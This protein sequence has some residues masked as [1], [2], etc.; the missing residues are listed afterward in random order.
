VAGEGRGS[1]FNLKSDLLQKG[2]EFSFFQVMR[3]LRLLGGEREMVRGEEPW[4][5]P[6]VRVHPDLSMA[7]PASDVVKVEEG[8]GESAAFSV[9]TSFLGL[10]GTSSPLPTFYTEDLVNEAVEDVS[11]TRGFIDIVNHR[12]YLLLFRSWAKYRPFLQVVEE[13]NSREAERLFCLTGLGEEELRKDVL[14]AYGLLRYLGLFTQ[15]P[16]SALGLVTLLQ[17]ALEVRPI[18]VIPCVERRVK[19]PPDQQ[20]SLGVSGRRLG[21][22]IFLGEEM[23]DRMGKFRLQVG[24]LRTEPFH[25]LLPGNPK[26][27]KL[28]FLTQF[29]LNDPL[30]YDLTL[31]LEEKEAATACLGAPQWSMLGWD[32]W[33]F[34]GESMGE[35]RTTIPPQAESPAAMEE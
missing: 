16:R 32:T 33:V 30:E 22:D 4:E 5:V 35:V 34:S 19:I 29:Y 21:E 13:K 20:C 7:F 15:F 27:Q 10:Y 23:D 31:I 6:N 26:H 11:L 1:T 18:E 3:L 17:D 25:S 8:A 2:P 9:T 12:L 24:P 14:G 28:T